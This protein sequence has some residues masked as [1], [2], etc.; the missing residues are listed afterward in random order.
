MA[1]NGYQIRNQKAIH[2]VTF[3]VIEWVDV[4]TRSAYKDILVESL[5]YCQREKGLIIYGWV[6]MSNHM[7][8]IIAVSDSSLS[9]VVRDYKKYT[10]KR[11]IYLIEKDQHESRRNWLLSMFQNAGRKNSKNECYQ[12]WRHGNHPVELSTNEMKDQ[13]IAYVHNNP[14]VAKVV[15]RPEDYLYSSAR[16]YAGEIGLLRVEYL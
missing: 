3:T 14:V 11:I 4:F 2:F 1:R 6:I 16:S 7:H 8:L 9:D 10:A 12:F 15:D 5:N 13:R